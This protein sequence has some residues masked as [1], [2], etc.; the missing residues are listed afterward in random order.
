VIIHAATAAGE[1]QAARIAGKKA[2][3]DPSKEKLVAPL[4]G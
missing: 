4:P 3:A 2:A 1:M